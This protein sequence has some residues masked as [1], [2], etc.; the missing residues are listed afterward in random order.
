MPPVTAPLPPVAAPAAAP[1][2]PPPPAKPDTSQ[3]PISSV[4]KKPISEAA[5]NLFRMLEESSKPEPDDVEDTPEP[6]TPKTAPPAAA[7]APAP[8]PEKPVKVSKRP[9][10]RPELPVAKSDA[11]PAPT[12]PPIAPPAPPDANW[13]DSLLDD[14]RL[15]LEDARL[16]EQTN[17]KHKGL[18]DKMGKFFR[19]QKKYL[20]AHP[21]ADEED[22]DYK[23]ILA[24]MPKLS[25]S[26]KREVAEAR[27]EGRVAKKYD[28][29][30]IDLEHELYVRDEEPK[31]EQESMQIRRHLAFNALPAEMLTVLKEKGLPVL[32]KEYAD[33]L[34][35]AGGLINTLVGDA[36]EL[37]RITRLNPKTQRTLGQ[38]ATNESHPKWEQHNRISNLVNAACDDFHRNAPQQEQIR[39]GK[40]FV[41]REEWGRLAPNARSQFWTFT[42][43]DEH[44][45]EMINRAMGWMPDAIASSIKNRQE[46]LKARGYVRQRNET[47]PAPPPP[48]PPTPSGSPSLPRS[49]PAPDP[50]ANTGGQLTQGQILARRLNGS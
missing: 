47:P 46:A 9:A 38:V 16:A 4:T 26:D 24:Q 11:P 33:E 49:S 36:K 31:V 17:E 14:E 42:N 18:A 15:A 5:H 44:V 34:E 12:P 19:E 2:P 8:N 43:S 30:L 25:A 29:K 45:R 37:L 1:I 32:Q 6:E 27:I 20:E 7:P 41:T 22:P 23:R 48:A 39:D 40:W 35:V 13:E 10:K 28:S 50:S 3:T 21:D